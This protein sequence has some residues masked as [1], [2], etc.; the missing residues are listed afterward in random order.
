MD[1]KADFGGPAGFDANSGRNLKI[2]GS[3]HAEAGE[4]DRPEKG[5]KWVI[6][7]GFW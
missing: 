1:L 2:N 3:F 4:I 7:G 6:L 5:V